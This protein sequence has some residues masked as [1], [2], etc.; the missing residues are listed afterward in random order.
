MKLAI[1]GSAG[2]GKST[3]ARCL[4]EQLSIAYIDEGYGPI[5]NGAS[6]TAPPVQQVVNFSRVLDQKNQQQSVAEHFVIDRS[7]IDLF[8][9][10]LG[11]G[12]NSLPQPTELFFDRCVL[13]MN[14]YDFVAVLPWM[15]IPL[16][17][18]Q[19]EGL[20]RVMNSWVQLKNHASI[21]GLCSM[22][23]PQ[24][25][26]LLVPKSLKTVEER[27]SWVLDKMNQ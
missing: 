8:H 17:Q 1:S 4:A 25:K 18:E 15:V 19:G 11:R 16:Q 2:T 9:L 12:I 20:K 3:L 5:F 13:S 6:R 14:T 10:W 22:F 7:P 26:L 24:S 27:S 23:V 21:A